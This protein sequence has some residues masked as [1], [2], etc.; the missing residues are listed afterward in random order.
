MKKICSTIIISTLLLGGC[1]NLNNS[2]TN[3]VPDTMPVNEYKGQG[4]QPHAEKKVIELA[5]KHYNEY[6][7]LGE[8]FFQDNFGLKVKA[9]NVV[10]SGDGVEVFVHC[11]D[12][13]IVFNSSIV[14]T[15]DSL[16][17]KGSMR[18]KGE[19]DELSTQIG[20]VVSGFDYKA[21]KKEYDELYQYFKDNQKKYS[22][23]GFTKEAINKTQNSGYQNE[24]FWINGNPMT[25]KEYH[26]KLYPLITEN[27]KTFKDK[28]YSVQ[29]SLY[30][31]PKFEIVTNLFSRNKSYNRKSMSKKVVEISNDIEKSIPKEI[32]VN[33]LATDQI[34]NSNS[35]RYNQNYDHRV[36]WSINNE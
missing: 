7:E 21:N 9:T 10:G 28:Y 3:K 35:A 11:D 14:L 8:R 26:E 13:D 29:T 34:I 32:Q 31:Q 17:H 12:H 6:A 24:F 15:S 16:G 1:N 22:Y 23:Y 5:K 30:N 18:A 2:F 36:E 20:K 4:F 33:I 27:G 25:L 19:S